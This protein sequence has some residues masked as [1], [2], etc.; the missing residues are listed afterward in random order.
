MVA[1]L[2]GYD[3]CKCIT[4]VVALTSSMW[5]HQFSSLPLTSPEVAFCHNKRFLLVKKRQQV[6][7]VL[8]HLQLA[9]VHGIPPANTLS[10]R[11]YL[12]SK[13]QRHLRHSLLLV[14]QWVATNKALLHLHVSYHGLQ[15]NDVVHGGEVV[16]GLHC[17]HSTQ[18]RHHRQVTA[19]EQGTQ[20]EARVCVWGGVLV[21]VCVC[22]CVS[23]CVFVCVCVRACL[24]VC[25]RVCACVCV[26]VCACVLA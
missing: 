15:P 24:L 26:C 9:T 6:S 25:L 2:H 20:G 5:K 11:P 4:A 13:V 3:Q 21:C 12:D 17:E 14:I 19:C 23:V 10:C 1:T 18:A 7:N 22:V 16:L 8:P